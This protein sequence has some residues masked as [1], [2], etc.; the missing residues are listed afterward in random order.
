MAN[1]TS[2]L[3][4]ISVDVAQKEVIANALFDASSP[5]TL[6]GRRASTTA[7]LTWGYYG[8]MMLVGGIPTAVANGTVALT[9]SATNYVQV[10][11]L[12]AVVVNTTGFLGGNTPIYAIVTGAASVTSYTDHRTFL[13]TLGNQ[14]FDLSAML[15]GA[16]TPSA[17]LMRVPLARA[18]SFPAG[19]TASR[20]VASVAATAQTDFDIQLNGVSVGTMRFAAAASSATFIAAAAINA[21]AGD[22]LS[23]IAPASPDATLANVGFVLAGTR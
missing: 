12:A 16:P 2:P 17:L 23:V 1:S 18:V 14:P 9:A 10:T 6:F 21:V 8:G 13:Y 19:L 4:L 22:V 5:A 20:G 7:L 15:P 11:P 3:D